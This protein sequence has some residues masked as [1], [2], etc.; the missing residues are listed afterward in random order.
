MSDDFFIVSKILQ[1][2]DLK[3][4]VKKLLQIH[5]GSF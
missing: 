5:T 2:D 1:G 3:E 4:S